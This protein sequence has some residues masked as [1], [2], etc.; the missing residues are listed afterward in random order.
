MARAVSS[1]SSSI[2]LIEFNT[3]EQ[4]SHSAFERRILCLNL[5]RVIEI[6]YDRSEKRY[7]LSR[8]PRHRTTDLPVFCLILQRAIDWVLAKQ[9]SMINVMYRLLV[10]ITNNNNNR[11]KIT[12][13]VSIFISNI[14]DDNIR[15]DF[16]SDANGSYHPSFSSVQYLKFYTKRLRCTAMCIM[17]SCVLPRHTLH[18]DAPHHCPSPSRKLSYC[19]RDASSR[20]RARPQQETLCLPSWVETKRCS[21]PLPAV[22]Q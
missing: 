20:R 22:W 3:F 16:P 12:F 13:A 10:L 17:H 6:S 7:Q 4:H 21:S 14:L 9:T 2:I 18:A 8:L 5:R 1:L 11:K 15:R 19:E